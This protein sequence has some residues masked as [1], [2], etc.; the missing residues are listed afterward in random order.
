MTR[1]QRVRVAN[2]GGHEGKGGLDRTTESLVRKGVFV[3]EEGAMFVTLTW[4][5]GWRE[6]AEGIRRELAEEIRPR[7]SDGAVER[8]LERQFHPE[9]REHGLGFEVLRRGRT[10]YRELLG[11][12]VAEIVEGERGGPSRDL[13][14]RTKAR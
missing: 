5:D 7:L 10:L 1:G 12:A 11:T 8:L 4:G 14:S 9:H 2:F 13:S 3:A 6:R